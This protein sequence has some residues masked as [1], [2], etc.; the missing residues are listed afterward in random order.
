MTSRE[1]VLAALTGKRPDRVPLNFLP[2]GI[3]LSEKKWQ[4]VMAA[5]RLFVI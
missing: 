1:R 2:V 3:L 4:R 5:S